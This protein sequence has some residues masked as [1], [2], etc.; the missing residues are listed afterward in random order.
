MNLTKIK[1]FNFRNYSNV[2]IPLNNNMNIFIGAN[3]QG[4]TNILEAIVILSLTK[5]FRFGNNQNFIRFGQKCCKILGSVKKNGFVKKLEVSYDI[6]NNK[7]LSI[8]GKNV[9]VLADYI[10]SLNVIFFSPDDLD[11]IKGAPNVRRSLLNVELSQLSSKYLN[12]YNEYNKLLKIRNEY[13]KTMINGQ[14][15]KN[16]LDIITEQLIKKAI[17]IYLERKD[18]IS[19]IN[20]KINYYYNLISNYSGLLVKYISNVNFE[21]YDFD[22]MYKTLFSIYEKNYLKEINNGMTLYGPHRDD[23]IFLCGEDDLKLFG[24]QGQQK[25]AVLSFK[26]AEISIF[27]EKCGTKPILLLDDIFGE[28]DIKKRNQ[29]LKIIN[30]ED[31][32]SIVTTTDLKNIS[33]EYIKDAFIYEVKNG[34]VFR[35]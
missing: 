34:I 29:V 30:S 1:L 17:I 19:M 4:K 25:L 12:T 6:L 32:Q 33:K 35:K 23:F 27:Y 26:I 21:S 7:D 15:N 2:E 28:L 8:N 9:R 22:C 11:I 31:I 10:S 16:Y 14:G 3:A 13:L 20:E 18:Y 24:S 5:S